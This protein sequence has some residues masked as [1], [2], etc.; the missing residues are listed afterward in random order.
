MRGRAPARGRVKGAFAEL[1]EYRE[2]ILN[3]VSKE[4]AEGIFSGFVTEPGEGGS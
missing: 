1:Y 3:L 2:L 4:Y